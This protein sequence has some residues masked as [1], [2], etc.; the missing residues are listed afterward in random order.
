MVVPVTYVY[1]CV[2]FVCMLGVAMCL[3][4]APV[5]HLAVVYMLGM[6]LLNDA[7]WG[8]FLLVFYNFYYELTF[9]KILL[10]GIFCGLD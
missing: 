7:R 9:L 4:D 3:S 10:V 8:L 5:W 2:T 6:S 1:L